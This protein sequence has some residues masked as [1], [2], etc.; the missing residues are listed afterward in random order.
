MPGSGSCPAEHHY[1]HNKD[2]AVESHIIAIIIEFSRGID[3]KVMQ[4]ICTI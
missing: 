3:N 4:L 2:E 1:E